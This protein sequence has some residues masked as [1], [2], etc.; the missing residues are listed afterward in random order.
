MILAPEYY[1]MISQI[2]GDKYHI[3]ACKFDLCISQI[4]REIDRLT[5]NIKYKGFASTTPFLLVARGQLEYRISQ[6]F[7]D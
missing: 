2:D 4:S 5:M 3:I 6:E 1:E 7:A